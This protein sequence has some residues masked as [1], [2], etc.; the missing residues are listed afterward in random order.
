MRKPRAI[1]LATSCALLVG[2]AAVLPSSPALAGKQP[3]IGI[4]TGLTKC[5]QALAAYCGEIEVPLDR[6][7]RTA[8]T[9]T[10]RFQY[11]PPTSTTEPQSTLVAHEGGPG[12][13]TTDSSDYFLDLFAPLMDQRAALLVDERGTGLSDP[14]D[15]PAAQSYVGDWIENN[16][17]CGEQLGNLSDLY[18]TANAAADMA[19]VV[20][21]L[22]ISSIDLYGDSYG[23]FFSQTFVARYPDLV[24]SAIFDG[25]Y[26]IEGLDPWY[27]TTATR[28]KDNLKLFCSRSLA[29]CPVKPTEMIPLLKSVL[30]R[31]RAKPITTSAPDGYGYE[32]TVT[33]TPRRVLDTLL[34]SDVTPGYVRSTPAALVAL[35]AGNPRPFAR[36]V[37][38]VEGPSSDAFVGK[39]GIPQP[40]AEIR[41]FSEG[42]YLAYACTDY[43]QL[44]DKQASFA[45]RRQQYNNAVSKLS[46]SLVAPWT[47]GEW[48]DS[49]F[50]VYDYC[51]KWPKPTVA[52]PP[53]PAGPYPNT[54]VLVLN[55]DLDLRTDVYQAR[56]VA[57]NF[58]NST[59]LEVPNA[60][61]VTAIYDADGCS[62][63]I[64]R[65]FIRTL[66]TGDTSCLNKISEHRVVARFAES[67]A[68]VPEATPFGSSDRSTPKDRRAAYVAMEAVADVL[69][70]WYA[71]P[72]Y[73][74]TGLYGG[75]FSQYTTTSGPFVSRVWSLKLNRYRWVKDVEV[76][77][78]GTMPRGAGTASMQ[79]KLR[80]SATAGGQLTMTWQTRQAHGKA[81]L[82]GTLGGRP[83]SVQVPAPSYY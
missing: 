34:Y 30:E 46:S 54:P 26:P 44:W 52:Q 78:T 36:M 14:I 80:G 11:Y 33:I 19:A 65:R 9:T 81:Q 68:D 23:S 77:G 37:A 51:I 69:D 8:G 39:T 49:D 57:E 75:Q 32:V 40:N 20:K 43:P 22:G 56:E 1:A 31:V 10:I 41:S 15:C 74:G 25:T 6:T 28:L 48:A 63:A 67:A 73:T 3:P 2:L 12:Y 59:Y 29:T 82:T 79:L 53:K 72:G 7:G 70:R 16:R 18:T 61:H 66:N 24:R 64:A 50:F 62:S 42:A 27:G 58:P 55:G 17:E 71:I 47:P 60:G 4:P 38:E 76:T 5:T 83:I 35:L 21:Y 45:E 13:A